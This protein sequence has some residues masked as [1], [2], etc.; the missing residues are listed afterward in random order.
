MTKR[1]R[2]VFDTNVFVSAS[3]SKN[4][5]SPTRELLERWKRNEFIL[6]VCNQ[7]AKELIEILSERGL[8]AEEIVDQISA[9]ARSA[10]WVIVPEEKIEDLLSD[11][12]DNVVVACAAEGA[13]NYLVTYDPHFDTLGGNYRGIKIVKAI[14]FLEALRREDDQPG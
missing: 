6:L 13:A 1:P 3:L 8:T 11:P 2:A 4:A 12:D 5:N 9:L 7:I 10:E 14:P